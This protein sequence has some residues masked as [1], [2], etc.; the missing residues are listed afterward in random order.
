MGNKLQIWFG[1]TTCWVGLRNNKALS[2]QPDIAILLSRYR[3]RRLV[4]TV[5]EV[6]CSTNKAVYMILLN[7]VKIIHRNPECNIT[8]L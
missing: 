5:R 2:A 8:W 4:G 6:V 3:L 7:V 1:W